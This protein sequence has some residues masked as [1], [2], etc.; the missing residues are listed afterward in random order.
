MY[1][2]SHP[3]TLGFALL[4]LAGCGAPPAPAPTPATAPAA[5]RDTLRR[6]VERYWQDH[7]PLREAISAQALADSLSVERR[8]LDEVRTL[9]AA[10]LDPAS[11]LTYD[12]FTRQRQ[13][14]IEGFTY[15]A[16]L[17]AFD[18][19]DGM[20]LQFARS[21]ADAAQHPPLTPKQSEDW[22]ERIDAYV[23][24]SQQSILNMREGLRRGFISPRAVVERSLPALERLGEDS[25]ANVFNSGPFKA[26]LES[27]ADPRGNLR[28]A[29]RE[30]LLPAYRA[31]HDFLEREYLP[32]ARAG[33]ALSELPL[34]PSWYAY[35]VKCATGS[36][37]TAAEIHRLGTSEVERLHARLQALAGGGAAAPGLK[38]APIADEAALLDA[39]RELKDRALAALPVAFSAVPPADFE[40]RAGGP[41]READAP[42]AYQPADPPR[43]T[44]A[45]L[46]VDPAPDAERPAG[47][48]IPDFLEA[49]LPGHHYQSSLQQQ[50]TDLPRFRR[51]GTEPAFVDGWGVYAAS[52]GEELGFYRDDAAKA[53]ALSRQIACAAALVVDTGLHAEGWTR[54]QAQD[55][56]HSQLAL[57]A[58]AADLVIDR[59]AARPG[60]ALACMMGERGLQALRARAQQALGTRF[61]L[62]DFHQAL[63]EDGAMPLDLLDAKMKTW[64]ESR[65]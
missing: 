30:K 9:P 3:V 15:P 1:R 41:L 29:I 27:R 18:P 61:D 60:D 44:P 25:A 11:R 17:L 51:F 59:S 31:L 42:L 65:R 34:G 20:P 39:Y 24:W 2:F 33:L 32:R 35:R 57:E 49:A 19:F 55:Y 56:L 16:E 48:L 46:F 40:I 6:I 47:V 7:A 38:A 53:G 14:A 5:P 58:A 13:L 10:A 50:R 23:A 22:R 12:I 52:L 37:L 26:N 28:A 36:D 8:Y 21:A 4:A 64:M 43:G 45:I 62:R 54:A 63:L